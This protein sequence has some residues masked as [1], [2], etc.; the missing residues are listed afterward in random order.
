MTSTQPAAGFGGTA[1]QPAKGFGAFGGGSSSFSKP[2]GG[3]GAFSNL[4]SNATNAGSAS[5]SSTTAPAF[6]SSG[7]TAFGQSTIWAAIIWPVE[8]WCAFLRKTR[9]WCS[10]SSFHNVVES[11][12]NAKLRPKDLGHLRRVAQARLGRW[13]SPIQRLAF[14]WQL[15]RTTRGPRHHSVHS[16]VIKACSALLRKVCSK[17]RGRQQLRQMVQ[18]PIP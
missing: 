9:F 15:H 7:S 3:F 1:I 14:Q 13:R 6:G 8:L 11:I 16:K 10:V 12:F 5:Q 18:N 4:G 17:V 2:S